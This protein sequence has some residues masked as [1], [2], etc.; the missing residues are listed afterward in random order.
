[1]LHDALPICVYARKIL[2]PPLRGPRTVSAR[3]CL[4]KTRDRVTMAT[5]CHGGHK[6]CARP[7]RPGVR[8]GYDGR[9]M[10]WQNENKIMRSRLSTGAW[11]WFA[12]A[13]MTAV[14]ALTGALRAQEQGEV[15][16]A[17][18]VSV[19]VSNSVD[20]G[21]Y[22]L[23]MEGIAKALEDPEVLKAILNGPQGGILFS[24]VTWADKPKFALG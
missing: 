17:L 12:V 6:Q 3:A 4:G 11:R 18:S 13:A 14:V 15:D 2:P 5:P 9:G 1:A 24:M 22:R 10:I 23:Q 16:T 21:R 8:R 20:E 7:W 19:D